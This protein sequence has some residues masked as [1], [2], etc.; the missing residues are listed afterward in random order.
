MI[1]A[2]GM[3]IEVNTITLRRSIQELSPSRTILDWFHELGGQWVTLGSDAHAPEKI[4]YRF[5]DAL[6]AVQFAGFKHLASFEG[7]MPRA[8]QL[9]DRGS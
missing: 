3:A 8:I 1:A 6:A 7:R 4:G 5:Q 9:M 2:K